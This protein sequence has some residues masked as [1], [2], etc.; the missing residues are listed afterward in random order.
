M[1]RVRP[2]GWED[3]LFVTYGDAETAAITLLCLDTTTGQKL[4]DRTF[5]GQVY[6]KHANNGYASS[7]PAVDADHIYITWGSSQETHLVAVTHFG[8]PVWHRQPRGL[9]R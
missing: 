8:K 7:T 4:W 1:V 2:V 9:F 6:S 5:Y 3:R